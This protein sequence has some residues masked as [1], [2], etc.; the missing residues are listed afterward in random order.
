M[1]RAMLT[2]NTW[3]DHSREGYILDAS[4]IDG[5]IHIE[6]VFLRGKN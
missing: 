5:L 6:L 4:Y 2:F 3:N 1:G